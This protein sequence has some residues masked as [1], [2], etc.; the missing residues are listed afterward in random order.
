[1]PAH[2]GSYGSY[3]SHVET[4]SYDTEKDDISTWSQMQKSV[5][6]V[7]CVAGVAIY[8]LNGPKTTAHDNDDDDDDLDDYAENGGAYARSE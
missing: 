1:M 3:G 6:I 4:R 2:N 7:A 5:A 8:A